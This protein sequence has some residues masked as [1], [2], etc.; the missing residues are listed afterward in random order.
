MYKM[1]PFKGIVKA[2]KH[3]LFSNLSGMTS[4]GELSRCITFLFPTKKPNPKIKSSHYSLLTSKPKSS[5]QIYDT[6]ECVALE[7]NNTSAHFKRY[8]C[9]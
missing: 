1:L 9:I 6:N 4:F 5:T 7:S 2:V 3:I 8:F